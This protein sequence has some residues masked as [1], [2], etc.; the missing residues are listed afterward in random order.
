MQ[1]VYHPSFDGEGNVCI[2]ITRKE[3][4]SPMCGVQESMMK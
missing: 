3:V 4:W 1:K 2:D